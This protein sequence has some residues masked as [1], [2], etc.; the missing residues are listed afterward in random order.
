[1][2]RAIYTKKNSYK[3]LHIE[4]MHKIVHTLNTIY[5]LGARS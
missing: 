2:E 3:V 5:V 4:H 1:M